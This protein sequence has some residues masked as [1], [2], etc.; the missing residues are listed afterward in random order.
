MLRHG[1]RFD[2]DRLASLVALPFL[3]HYLGC[4]RRQRVAVFQC[5]S[6][7]RKGQYRYPPPVLFAVPGFDRDLK[8]CFCVDFRDRGFSAL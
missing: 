4:F 1:G 8:I 3:A 2:T 5:S 7:H 6:L